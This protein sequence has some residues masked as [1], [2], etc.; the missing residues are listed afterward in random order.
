MITIDKIFAKEIFDSRGNPTL[1][2]TVS[3]GGNDGAFKVPSGAS[4]GSHEAVELH[5]GDA[6][7]HNGKGVSKAIENVNG[8]INDTLVGLDVTN[9]REIDRKMIELDGTINKSHLGANSM[10]GVSVA[11]AKCAAKVSGLQTF[12]YL[13]TL[14]EIKPSRDFP[15]LYMN[16]INGGMH[17]K[18]RLAFQ[19]Y[20]VV[21]QTDDVE[22]AFRIGGEIQIKLKDII[23]NELGDQNIRTGD[24][25]GYAL[26]V[27]D[28]KKP[29]ELLRAATIETGNQDKVRFALDVAASSFF[30]DGKYFVNGEYISGDELG[31]IYDNLINEFNL[32]SIEDPFEEE[33][34]EGF[35]NLLGKHPGLRILGDDLTTTNKELVQK[36]IDKQSINAMIIKPNQIGT[37]TETLDTMKLARENGVDCIV[38]HR[39]GETNDDFIADLA[40]AFGCYG[41][42]SGAPQ[43]EERA[44]KYR[45]L[46]EI[47]NNDLPD[48]R[49]VI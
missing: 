22:D 24:E 1:E 18:T 34:F 6:N 32:L 12:E 2:V 11:A 21:P 48:S 19:E 8:I 9:Q 14:T 30:K 47:T 39:S 44:I 26:D 7:Y 46:I 49:K 13:R 28:I 31:K 25:G 20:H 37:L 41:L 3:S 27:L 5:D 33:D 29:L 45:R 4:T 10:I 15:L 36:A 35:A 17:A 38:S 23:S 43:K 40:Y 16:L 42:K